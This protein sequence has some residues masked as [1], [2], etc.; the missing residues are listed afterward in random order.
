MLGFHYM[1]PK[2]LEQ[3]NCNGYITNEKIQKAI[4][5]GDY[6]STYSAQTCY[7]DDIKK[8]TPFK[9]SLGKIVQLFYKTDTMYLKSAVY[10][11]SFLL[12]NHYSIKCFNMLTE[13]EKLNFCIDF[14]QEYYIENFFDEDNKIHDNLFK[15]FSFD[16][17]LKTIM[18]FFYSAKENELFIRNFILLNY[19]EIINKINLSFLKT[20][21]ENALY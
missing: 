7:E 6:F 16:H 2:L 4:S 9:K 1:Y 5:A 15:E 11:V 13:E 3:L 17:M 21:R 12:P 8:A 14:L 18:Y 19:V 10:K 20:F